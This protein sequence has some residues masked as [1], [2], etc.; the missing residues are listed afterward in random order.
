[1]L[2][3]SAQP[4]HTA[5]DLVVL[6]LD[7]VVYVGP[8]ALPGAAAGIRS[9]RD[10]GAQ[11]AFVTNNAARPPARVAEHLTSLGVPAEPGDVVTS[12]QA[13]ASLLL[14]DHGP[15]APVWVLGAAG[16]REAVT[17]VGLLPVPAPGSG[18]RAGGG[19]GRREE[20]L[21][22]ALVTGYGPD[23]RWS[24]LMQAAVQVAGGLPWVA[25]NTDHSLPTPDGRAPGH[26]V[27]VRMLADF[28]GR[29]PKVAGKPAR[30]LLD[31]TVRRLGGSR[32]LMVGD[33]LDTDVE[34]AR[35]AGM[36]S[37]LVLTGVSGLG[38]VLGAPAHTRTTF[39]AH[40]LGG[41]GRPHAAPRRDGSGWVAGTWRAVV[42]DGRLEV[43][44]GP[45]GARVRAPGPP[46]PDDWWRAAA[47]AAWQHLDDTGDVAAHDGLR[48]PAGSLP[49]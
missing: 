13:A 5:H 3:E 44:E 17:E 6:D 29:S 35:N 8:D 39:L 45:R 9:A 10:A 48:P 46:D 37:L 19:E 11:V 22:V 26:G 49:A 42:R 4:L 12:A 21:P 18:G 32:P 31:E 41:L 2:G 28:A 27:L 36:A 14:A 33:R 7:G 15:G 20:P 43:T 25:S 24:E 40:D 16:L 38:E 47:C 34:G 30:P 1:M 23:V